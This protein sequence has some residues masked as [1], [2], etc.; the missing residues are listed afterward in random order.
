MQTAPDRRDGGDFT[1][2]ID[3]QPGQRRAHLVEKLARFGQENVDD[4]L[5]DGLI[6]APII[7]QRLCDT[8]RRQRFIRRLL[9]RRLC[10]QLRFVRDWQINA[11][12]VGGTDIAGFVRWPK[13]FDRVGCVR[14]RCGLI[15]LNL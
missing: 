5:I 1:R 7:R 13:Q 4:F 3:R 14:R 8:H 11:G 10:K 6:D 12:I 2:R 9:L 15:G